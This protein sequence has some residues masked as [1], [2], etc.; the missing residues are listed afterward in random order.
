MPLLIGMPHSSSTSMLQELAEMAQL[1]RRQ[2]FPCTVNNRRGFSSN[3]SF[4]PLSQD[5][6][7]VCVLSART[8]NHWVQEAP[9][10]TIFK[11]HLAPTPEHVAML[12]ASCTT[13][14]VVLVR[15]AWS[16]SHAACER[17]RVSEKRT[18]M[19]QR[20]QLEELS[21]FTSARLP[22]LA[23]WR[24][25]WQAVAEAAPENV[26]MLS[27][28]DLAVSGRAVL[29][30]RALQF[31]GLTQRQPYVERKALFI[32]QSSAVCASAMRRAV[33][34]WKHKRDNLA[35]ARDR[36]LAETCR[37]AAQRR[38]EACRGTLQRAGSHMARQ[39]TTARRQLSARLES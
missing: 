37:S 26:L 10:Q 15:S 9:R 7:D 32:N 12:L 1:P 17:R 25:G 11:Q 22:A 36:A 6:G 21:N 8:L 34:T 38:A 30:P 33:S 18:N 28:E 3:E 29:L 23:A 27:Y 16:S 4:H 5:H 14:L 31:W 13:R 2:E 24:A 35:A 39:L 19:R 20:N